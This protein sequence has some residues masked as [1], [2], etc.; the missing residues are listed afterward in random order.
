MTEPDV[1]SHVTAYRPELDTEWSPERR[2][3]T[4]ANVFDS[5][6]EHATP[7]WRLTRRRVLAGATVAVAAAAAAV[8]AATVLPGG[9][10]GGPSP[11]EAKIIKQL[12]AVAGTHGQPV[13]DGQYAYASETI[14][15]AGPVPVRHQQVWTSTGGK[16]WIR[17]AP[18]RCLTASPAHPGPFTTDYYNHTAAQFAALPT[19]ADALTAFISAHP[20]GDNRG[21][22]NLWEAVSELLGD[23]GTLV[24]PAVRSAAITVLTRIDGTSVR[25]H[26]RDTLGRPAIAITRNRETLYF[27]PDTSRLLEEAQTAG[28][29]QGSGKTLINFAGV[30]NT[31]PDLPPC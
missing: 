12:A 7:V 18:A 13:K 5:P 30:V 31:L 8:V 17:E 28:N 20:D 2:D 15:A 1:L 26:L 25:N 23:G 27:N 10:P 16:V 3:H 9:T 24:P 14:V 6:R 29:S 11:A 4:L 21:D 22:D 19:T